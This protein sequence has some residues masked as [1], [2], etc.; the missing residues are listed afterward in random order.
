M[1]H[2]DYRH[3]PE[4]ITIASRSL[5]SSKRSFYILL[6]KYNFVYSPTI[7]TYLIWNICILIECSIL[8]AR[9]FRV[10]DF[11]YI[12]I[13]PT[14]FGFRRVLFLAGICDVGFCRIGG[15]LPWSMIATR[16]SEVFK[17]GAVT[18]PLRVSNILYFGLILHFNEF[19]WNM[20]R[21]GEKLGPEKK[22]SGDD[23]SGRHNFASFASFVFLPA[24]T[25]FLSLEL[26]VFSL[27]F[28]ALSRLHRRVLAAGYCF[29]WN[30]C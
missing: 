3:I 8:P 28:L 10:F 6:R 2:H 20:R 12:F 21:H 22:R 25:P 16:C 24:R 7:C 1:A 26:A 11:I 9:V 17:L 23:N 15:W 5:P 14:T 4:G 13:F 29:N 30:L 18:F 27:R 19:A